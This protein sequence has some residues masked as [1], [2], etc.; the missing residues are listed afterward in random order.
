[1]YKD[2]KMKHDRLR[3]PKCHWEK[4]D[5]G[6]FDDVELLFKHCKE[7]IQHFDTAS[8]PPSQ[9]QYTCHWEG[10]IKTYKKI[11]LLENHLR[12]HTGDSLEEFLEI[13]IRDQAKA[14][15]KSK[16]KKW[17]P[18]V[19]KWCPQIYS[20]SKSTYNDIRLSIGLKLPSGRT[21]S[22][23]KNFNSTKSGW[24]SGTIRSMRNK[25]DEQKAPKHA[26]LG[27]LF[28]D[29]TKIKEELVFDSS[30][31]ELIG[32][33]DIGD[34]SVKKLL[35]NLTLWTDWQPTFSNFSIGVSSTNLTSHVPISLQK[36]ECLTAKPCILDGS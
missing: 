36:S 22:D 13:L 32:F 9:R 27:G 17:N 18:A 5:K 20:K 35:T 31:W 3:N 29:E 34:D 30:S 2:V 1:M 25:L 26:N 15:N 28:F 14:L 12:E 21:L 24:R 23:Y 16:V 6:K 10:C 8:V 33:V 11:K 4:C 7:H 19:I